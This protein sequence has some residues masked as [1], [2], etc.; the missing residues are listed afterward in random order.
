M[1][2]GHRWVT[3]T[4][5]PRHLPATAWHIDPQG[6]LGA[7]AA[8]FAQMGRLCAA[9]GLREEGRGRGRWEGGLLLSLSRFLAP[10]LSLP[11]SLSAPFLS[12]PEKLK[13]RLVSGFRVGLHA[14]RQCRRAP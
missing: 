13:Y 14:L 10:Q 5:G 7:T 4:F 6:H 11:S 1:T 12:F 9:R 3:E 2:L 8:M